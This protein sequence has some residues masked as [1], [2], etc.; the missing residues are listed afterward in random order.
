MSCVFIVMKMACVGIVSLLLLVF[1]EA[2]YFQCFFKPIQFFEGG[3]ENFGF[4]SEKC[5][6]ELKEISIMLNCR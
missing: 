3:S 5:N 6:A 4:K 1:R 2:L